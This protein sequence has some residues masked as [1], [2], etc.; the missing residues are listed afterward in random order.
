MARKK[1]RDLYYL[2]PGMARGAR[3]RFVRNLRISI[4]V[5]LL[6]G[7]IIAFLMYYSDKM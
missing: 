3:A 6:V 7:G 4:I 1:E 5:G 2:L